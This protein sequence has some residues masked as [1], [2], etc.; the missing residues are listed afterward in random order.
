MVIGCGLSAAT[1]PFW[2]ISG[3]QS[4]ET[5][6]ELPNSPLGTR[7]SAKLPKGEDRDP[8]NM[9]VEQ[10]FAGLFCFVFL[11]PLDF[12]VCELN[13]QG[14]FFLSFTVICKCSLACRAG[15]PPPTHRSSH[16]LSPSLEP[17]M[18]HIYLATLAFF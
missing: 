6:P 2:N 12:I 10:D 9:A 14:T 11:K 8:C 18:S 15:F 4:V 13:I 7:E 1:A 16:S 5:L 17:M 3:L